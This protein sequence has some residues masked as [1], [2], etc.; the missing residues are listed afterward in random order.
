MTMRAFAARAVLSISAA[1]ATSACLAADMEFN[2]LTACRDIAEIFSSMDRSS[3][4]CGYP[5]GTLD[6]AIRDVT[7]GS[8]A[9]LCFKERSP[10]LALEGFR[11]VQIA[12]R[13]E[14]TLACYRSVN[15]ELLSD[16]RS[17]FSRR[18]AAR[19]STYIEQAKKCPGSNGD[20][21]RMIE[22][23]FP[24]IF[25]SVAE[26][27]FGFNVQYGGAK[28]AKT[29]VSHGFA[30]TS[31]VIS[32]RGPAAIEYVVY[33]KGLENELAAQTAHGNW[34]L[35]IDNSPDFFA[36]FFKA[37]KR[38]GMDAYFAAIDINIERSPH[39]PAISK[40][41]SL[42]DALS[43]GVVVKLEDE[44]FI[45]MDD[46]DLEHHTGQTREQMNNAIFQGVPFG[47]RNLMNGRI[48]QFRLLMKDSGMD[49][50]KGGRG[51]IGAYV[52]TMSGENG[53]QV[54]FGSYSLM[55]V[56]FGSCASSANASRKYVRNLVDESKKALLEELRGR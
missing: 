6:R 35:R 45:E 19:T 29:M 41:P 1:L 13:G 32:Q 30:K 17:N 7:A 44:G 34:L 10:V 53:V 23:T 18:Y 52:F 43:D 50:A 56:G 40:A 2:R 33:A 42:L 27:E 14:K 20:A 48:P 21:S 54:D 4:G 22:T 24:A 5:V 39:A 31:P 37:L 15:Q 3:V 38:Q 47:A 11:C 28:P 9:K 51:A 26:H 16:Y 36:Q 46:E 49:C 25:M 55:V 8:E 12:V